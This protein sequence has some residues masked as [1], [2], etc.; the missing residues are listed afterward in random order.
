MRNS[1]HVHQV[2]KAKVEADLVTFGETHAAIWFWA[3]GAE[4]E[5]E[6]DFRVFG[7]DDPRQGVEALTQIARTALE[8]R[9]K[10]LAEIE[11]AGL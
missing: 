3:H 6:C 4:I 1:K 7:F 9:E 5:G 10:L 11:R 2:E 8:A